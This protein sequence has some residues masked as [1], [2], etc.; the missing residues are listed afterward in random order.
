MS[1]RAAPFLAHALERLEREIAETI[2]RVMVGG[3]EEAVHDMRVAIRRCRTVLREARGVFGKRRA[4]AV[5]AAFTRVHRATSEL[6]DEEVLE[7][8]LAECVGGAPSARAWLRRRKRRRE[9]LAARVQA[10]LASGALDDARAM[11]TDM[12][13]SEVPPERDRSLGPFARRAV[14][15]ARRDVERLRRGQGTSTR[16]LHDLRIAYK[17]LRYVIEI[18]AP[19]LPIDDRALLH[20]SVTFQKRLG[21]LNDLAVARATVSAARLPEEARALVLAALDAKWARALGRFLEDHD[22]LLAAEQAEQAEQ[23]SQAEQAGQ[24]EHAAPA[25]PARSPRPR[26]PVAKGARDPAPRR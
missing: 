24:T 3:D 26:R 16:A 5:R 9:R 6:R 25:A 22:P 19:A 12:L 10:L 11:L 1:A 14:G 15:R 23:T 17:G 21:V 20:P 4:D 8:T 7:E 13:A 18:F 2:P